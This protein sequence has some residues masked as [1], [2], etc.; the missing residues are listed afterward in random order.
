MFY[1]HSYGKAGRNIWNYV[2]DSLHSIPSYLD[3]GKLYSI[4]LEDC[5][6]QGDEVEELMKIFSLFIS[7]EISDFRTGLYYENP[8]YLE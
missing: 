8:D 2:N 7:D 3:I 4:M 5:V 1:G 6:E